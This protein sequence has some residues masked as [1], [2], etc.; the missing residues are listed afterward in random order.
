[1]TVKEK[2]ISAFTELYG[3]GNEVIRVYFAPGRVNLIGE[4]T[5]YNNGYVFPCALTFGTYLAVRP[6]NRPFLEFHSHGFEYNVKIPLQSAYRKESTEWIN[7]PLGIIETLRQEGKV[8]G[9]LQLYYR[10][11]IPS[12][13]GLSSSASI[14]MVTAF[15]LNDVYKW[16]YTI[17]DLIRISK[18]AENEFIG[19]NCGIMDMF[20]IGQ[21]KAGHAIFLDC[22]TLNFQLVP[23]NITGHKLVIINTNKK[24]G[25][26]ESKYNE[27]VEECQR[28]LNFLSKSLKANSLG[29]IS[30]I[31]FRQN[32]HLITDAIIKKRARHVITENQ[33]VLDAVKALKSNDFITFG[34]LMNDSH[35][36]LRDDYEVTGFELDS[37]VNIMQRQDGVLGARMTGAGFGGCALAFVNEHCLEKFLDEVTA[38]YHNKTGLRAGVYLPEIGD[39]VKR[40]A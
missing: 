20:S 26:G 39:G 21:G 12:A 32:E 14:E 9:G 22:G 30:L 11:D 31:D 17:P 38:S 19:V 37:L 7:Y 16:K 18:K 2:I 27:R 34:Q 3:E 1:M 13:A 6:T 29:E 10:G 8:S 5:D 25:L 4:H 28:A 33:R 24:R 35:A 40:I 36:S 15:A 23:A